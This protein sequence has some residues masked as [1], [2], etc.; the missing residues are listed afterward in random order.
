MGDLLIIETATGEIVSRIDIDEHLST[1]TR[2]KIERGVLRNMNTDRYHVEDEGE[3]R[4]A[5][6]MLTEGGGGSR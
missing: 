3:A 2:E 1:S 6:R 4:L 5:Q